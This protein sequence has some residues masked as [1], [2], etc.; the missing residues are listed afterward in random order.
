ML[1]NA[2][3]LFL[4]SFVRVN[5]NNYDNV[6]IVKGVRGNHYASKSSVGPLHLLFARNNIE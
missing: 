2:T 6:V 3:K 4:L 5:D 1:S